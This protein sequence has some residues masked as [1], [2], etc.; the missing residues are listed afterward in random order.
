MDVLRLI[1]SNVIKVL[2]VVEVVEAV[3]L[4]GCGNGCSVVSVAID[5]VCAGDAVSV[6]V[7]SSVINE[8]FVKWWS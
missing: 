3:W 8:S 6:S 5:N 2:C 4:R 7:K 1:N